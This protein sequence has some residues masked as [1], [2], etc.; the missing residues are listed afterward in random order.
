MLLQLCAPAQT[1]LRVNALSGIVRHIPCPYTASFNP[2][3]LS[4]LAF[5]S[6]GLATLP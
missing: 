2:P 1:S 6:Q 5:G 3:S 4:F